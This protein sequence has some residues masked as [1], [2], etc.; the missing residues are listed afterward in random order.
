[1]WSNSSACAPHGHENTSHRSERRHLLYV[2]LCTHHE[3]NTRGMIEV[4]EYMERLGDTN[5]AF[6]KTIPISVQYW[7]DRKRISSR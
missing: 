1:M 3:N 4:R 5:L 6:L 2:P 7:A